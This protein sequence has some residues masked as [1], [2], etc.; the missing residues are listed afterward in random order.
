MNPNHDRGS[1]RNYLAD[2]VSEQRK[3]LTGLG[4]EIAEAK[5]TVAMLLEDAARARA[6]RAQMWEA[7]NATRA[8]Q[9][10]I[11]MMVSGVQAGINDIKKI[12]T[13]I[14]EERHQAKGAFALATASARIAWGIV[15]GIVLAIAGLVLY[16]VKAFSA[17]P[18]SVK[19]PPLILLA[20]L[21]T[22]ALAQHNHAQHHPHYQSWENKQGVNCCNQMDCGA[23]ADADE[24]T[25][26]GILAVRV[27]GVWCPILPHHY[28]SRGNVPDASTSHVCVQKSW[29]PGVSAC[30]RLLCY[31]PKPGI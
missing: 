29:K 18:P 30:D 5:V 12:V 9:A 3:E 14:N 10:Q 11:T 24:R 20:L 2:Q 27:E 19:I 7:I 23:L 16:L 22:T 28:L 26:G 4:R 25:D 13:D 15:G 17:M 8:E 6:Q 1:G 21:G 31:Q